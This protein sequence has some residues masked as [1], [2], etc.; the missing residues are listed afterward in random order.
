VEIRQNWSRLSDKLGL[1]SPEQIAT[2]AK[3]GSRFGVASCAFYT[4][5]LRRPKTF[6]TVSQHRSQ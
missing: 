6:E 3:E 4:L 5:G 1:K 2:L